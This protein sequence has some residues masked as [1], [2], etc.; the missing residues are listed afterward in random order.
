M[1]AIIFPPFAPFENN[2]AKKE[3]LGAGLCLFFTIFAVDKVHETMKRILFSACLA[4]AFAGG[5]SAQEVDPNIARAERIFAFV[6]ANQADSLYANMADEVLPLVSRDALVG[7]M[8][9]AEYMAGR[10]EGRGP[11]EV[12]IVARHKSY[13]SMLRFKR[14]RLALLIV[15]NDAGRMLGLQLLLPEALGLD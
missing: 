9:K 10:Y 5:L 15:F 7:I 2:E 14:A 13:V 6:K 3:A 4:L 11:W 8:S 12:K 1:R